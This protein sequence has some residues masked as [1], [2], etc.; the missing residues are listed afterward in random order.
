MAPKVTK[1]GLDAAISAGERQKREESAKDRLLKVARKENARLEAQVDLLTLL[2]GIEVTPAEWAQPKRSGTS[3]HHAI[4]NLLLSDLHFDEI[5]D[6][7]AMRGMNAYNREIALK[8]LERLGDKTV[9]LAR[10]YISG[11]KYDGLF[12]W[13]NGDIV[14]GNIHDELRRTNAGADVIDTV[15]Y[16]ADPLAGLM[17]HLADF[18]GNVHVI[19]TVGNHARNSEKPMAK[20]AVKSSFDWL[21]MRIIWR[22][23]RNDSRFTWNIPESPDVFE[24]VYSTRYLCQHG[25][26]F[27]G[28]DQIAGPIRPVLFGDMR[29]LV[30]EVDA[31][32]GQAYDR[33]LVSHFHQYNVLGRGTIN[34]SVVG[35]NE[36]AKDKLK[37]RW[38]PP[39][40]ALWIDTPENGP[41]MH[42]PVLCSDRKAEGW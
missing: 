32:D 31:P 10:D 7:S 3:D 38:E 14:S 34:G 11:V 25:D 17:L 23:L 2:D 15:D 9:L 28:G 30:R 29:S 21:T 24:S 20:G 19:S 33:F 41:T 18:F 1:E 27:K 6:P 22:A 36:Y 12:L 4:A 13:V 40:Q 37:A 39:Q 16:W 5:V 26:A 42:L 8:R 35:Y